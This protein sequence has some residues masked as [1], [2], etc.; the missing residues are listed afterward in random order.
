MVAY[1]CS[2]ER[3]IFVFGRTQLHITSLGHTRT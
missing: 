1:A 2:F 3:D